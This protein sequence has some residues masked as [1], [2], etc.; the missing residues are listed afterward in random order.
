[1]GLRPPT[2][3]DLFCGAGGLSLGFHAAGCRI[4]A[5]VDIDEAAG[6]TFRAN[7]ERL[8]PEEPPLVLSGDD[9]DLE[10]IQA[11]DI[12]GNAVPPDI[13]IAGPPCQ[14]FSMI[15][16]A[17]LDSLSD[18]GFAGDP[19]NELYRAFVHAIAEWQPGAFLMENVPGMLS[20]EGRNVAEEAA[21]ELATK[22]YEVGYALLNAVWY[23]VPQYRS[24]LFLIGIRTD[25]GIRPIAPPGTHYAELPTGYPLPSRSVQLPLGFVH[26]S[27]LH[28]DLLRAAEPAITVG[29]ALGDL[30]VLRDHLESNYR[31]RSDFR[32][33][34]AYPDKPPCDYAR[35]MRSW[36]GLPGPSCVVDHAIRRTPR[37]YETFAR[38][39]PGDRYPEALAIANARL[40]AAIDML[41]G[42]GKH[43]DEEE[44]RR[45]IIPPYPVDIF[46][47]KWRKLVPDQP[48]WTVVAHLARDTYSHIH[49]DDEQARMI[50][51]REAARLQS[52]PDAY[53]FAGTMNDCFRLIGNAV[54]PLMAWAIAVWVVELLG[55]RP[56]SPPHLRGCSVKTHAAGPAGT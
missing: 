23:G 50:S 40:A 24:R 19:R 21:A 38:M 6:Q 45:T 43:V 1:V 11:A 52:F 29:E 36:P 42:A 25:F 12:L 35:L 16:R 4:Q 56:S 20:V 14:G 54:P 5:A 13:V 22:G 49:Y 9:A 55:S 47:D 28:V 37:D 10:Q 27:E 41:R 31:P 17:R 39:K 51:I 26:H 44:L 2:V 15:G 8:Q 32:R 34:M 33:E 7:F 3:I 53:Q 46:V 48:S 30:P 18:E